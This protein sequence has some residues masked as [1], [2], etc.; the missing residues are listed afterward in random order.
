MYMFHAVD[1]FIRLVFTIINRTYITKGTIMIL[2]SEAKSIL[3]LIN[4]K[5]L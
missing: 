3:L 2:A 5:R 4:V 1:D